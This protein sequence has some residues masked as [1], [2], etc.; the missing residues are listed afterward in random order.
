[1]DR[2]ESTSFVELV[3]ITRLGGMAKLPQRLKDFFSD[4]L[5]EMVELTDA[6]LQVKSQKGKTYESGS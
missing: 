4:D 1:V 5:K 2:A 6:A 3:E